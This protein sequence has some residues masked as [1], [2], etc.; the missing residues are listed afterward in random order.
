MT[1]V[2]M[3]ECNSFHFID[4]VPQ[5]L[6]GLDPLTGWYQQV[7]SVNLLN[8]NANASKQELSKLNARKPT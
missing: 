7:N 8:W 3:E 4:H 5:A 6:C 1:T 2:I